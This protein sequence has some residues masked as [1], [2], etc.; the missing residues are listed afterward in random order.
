MARAFGCFNSQ[1]FKGKYI[2]LLKSQFVA[3]ARTVVFKSTV[4]TPYQSILL[5]IKKNVGAAQN[6]AAL[7]SLSQR[8]WDRSRKLHYQHQTETRW[9]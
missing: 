8:L 4:L 2:Q 5:I 6:V 3:A 7:T 1:I 9:K